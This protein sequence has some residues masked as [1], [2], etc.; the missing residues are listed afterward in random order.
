MPTKIVALAV[1]SVILAACIINS[2]EN[3]RMAQDATELF[4]TTRDGNISETVTKTSE[5]IET[6]TQ[7]LVHDTINGAIVSII[8][9]VV[10]AL[11][12][13]IGVINGKS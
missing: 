11:V 5:F 8:M 12:G 9:I 4:K 1:L 2:L 3:L 13:V 6:Q 7:Q 10:S